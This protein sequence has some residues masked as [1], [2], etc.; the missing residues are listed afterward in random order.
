MKLVQLFTLILLLVPP[1][2]GQEP[3]PCPIEGDP[4]HWMADFCMSTL[5]TDDEIVAMDCI[6][7]ELRRPFPDD[8][9]AKVYYKRALCSLAVSR[10][11]YTGTIE[12]CVEDKNFM[13]STVRN[14]GVGN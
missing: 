3:Q 2:Y 5:E 4:I 9:A 14:Q 11:A 6:D 7:R 10:Q 12:S 13:G 1:V 8:C